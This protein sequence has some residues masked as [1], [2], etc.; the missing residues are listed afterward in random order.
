MQQRDEALTAAAAAQREA[1]DAL[2]RA[3]TKVEH[4]EKE[5]AE[6]RLRSTLL[7]Q[8]LAAEE[9]V[10]SERLQALRQQVHLWHMKIHS[11][12][13]RYS[14][15]KIKCV[16]SMHGLLQLMAWLHAHKR[17]PRSL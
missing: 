4:L 6:L 9:G 17:V 10:E 16:M 7:E 3:N 8:T 14:N 15:P 11:F 13:T 2:K 12:I 1:A 5:A